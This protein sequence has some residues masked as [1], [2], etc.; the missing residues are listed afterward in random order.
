MPSQILDNALFDIYNVLGESEDSLHMD[1]I[2]ISTKPHATSKLMTQV[3]SFEKL[4]LVPLVLFDE[5][6]L[7]FQQHPDSVVISIAITHETCSL[8]RP[9]NTFCILA[10]SSSQMRRML[11]RTHRK[12]DPDHWAA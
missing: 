12:N 7:G 1:K 4:D 6:Q 10:G 5:Y 8:A 11:F 2:N 3:L 9:N